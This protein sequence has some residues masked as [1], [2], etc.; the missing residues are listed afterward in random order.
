MKLL[1]LI[2]RD[3]KP[4]S[5]A[6]ADNIPWNDADF[7]ERMLQEHLSQDHDAASR[8]SEIIDRH[9]HWIHH[10]LLSA[11][12]A[13]ILDMGCGPGLYAHRLA[14]LGHTCVGIDYSPASIAYAVDRAEKE[15]LSCSYIHQ[16][17]RTAEYGTGY[18]LVMLIFGEFNVFK[19]SD[20]RSILQKAHHA[21][22]E[23]GVI[24]LEP[25]TLSAVKKIGQQA[26]SWYSTPAGLFSDQPHL[27]LQENFWDEAGPTST[28]RFFIIDAATYEVTRHAAS[29]QGYTDQQYRSILEECNFTDVRMYPSLGEIDKTAKS[30]LMAIVARK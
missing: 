24:L 13:R 16:D 18:N 8:R 23:G 3:K 17:I 11:K 30:D 28:A 22:C 4:V 5:W 10:Q 25:H 26:P 20:A 29:Y 9:V 1:D 19:P 14:K 21:L 7:S 15:N 2:D 12:P 6:E 27:C